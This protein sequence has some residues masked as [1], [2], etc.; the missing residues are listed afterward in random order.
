MIHSQSSILPVHNETT[1][2]IIDNCLKNLTNENIS[3]IVEKNLPTLLL[4]KADLNNTFYVFFPLYT[5]F[6]DAH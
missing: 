6:S 4:C 1:A 3:I 5:F 2:I